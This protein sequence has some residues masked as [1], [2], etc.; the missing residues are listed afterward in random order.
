VTFSRLQSLRNS[1]EAYKYVKPKAENPEEKT[2]KSGFYGAKTAKNW[3][4]TVNRLFC[5]VLAVLLWKA[6]RQ[7]AFR[8]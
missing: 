7:Y 2:A 3:R 6:S 8:V 1:N 5:T 4:L